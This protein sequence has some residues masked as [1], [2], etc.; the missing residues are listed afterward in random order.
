MQEATQQFRESND[1]PAL[2]V[3]ECCKTGNNPANGV[4]YKAQGSALYRAYADWC[5]E[6]G[7]KYASSTRV[8]ED[9][10]RLGFERDRIRGLTWWR[11]V[12]LLSVATPEQVATPDQDDFTPKSGFRRRKC[13]RCSNLAYLNLNLSRALFQGGE[14][15]DR[16]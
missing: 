6:N 11:G 14:Y 1:V 3:G 2:F 15:T 9:W 5:K 8:A 10:R 7:H 16:D 12:G 13:S 4:P